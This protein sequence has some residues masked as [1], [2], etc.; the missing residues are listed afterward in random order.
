MT[1]LL[2]A[3]R[4]VPQLVIRIRKYLNVDLGPAFHLSADPDPDP[5]AIINADRDPGPDKILQLYIL[6]V[7]VVVYI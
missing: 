7:K 4:E 2:H 6:D 3:G 5:G 1:I